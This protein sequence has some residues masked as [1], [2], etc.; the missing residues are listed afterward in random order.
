MEKI[1]EDEKKLNLIKCPLPKIIY[2]S[3][4]GLTVFPK[5]KEK[6]TNNTT[7]YTKKLNPQQTGLPSLKMNTKFSFSPNKTN[8]TKG[9][10]ANNL[11]NINAKKNFKYNNTKIEAYK[12]FKNSDIRKNKENKNQTLKDILNSYGLNRYYEKFI[13][14]GINDQNFNQIGFMN[15]KGLNDFMNILNIFPSHTT[16]MEQLY[17]HLKK[18]N[19]GYMQSQSNNNIHLNSSTKEIKNSSN[20]YNSQTNL[21]N[22]GSSNNLK[23]NKPNNN[24]NYVTLTF[25]RTN[26]KKVRTRVSHSQ[27]KSKCV[28]SGHDA[29]LF[30]VFPN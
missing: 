24:V 14:N 15:K 6:T 26:L 10:Q 25:N 29:E 7:Y 3:M 27:N 13:Q 1:N 17:F 2:M 30:S 9:K 12:E 16:K 21:N 28:L 20:S 22:S 23:N 8:Y 19:N 4:K 11:N 18:Q 5:S